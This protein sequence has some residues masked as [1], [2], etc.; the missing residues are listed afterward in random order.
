MNGDKQSER[1]AGSMSKV[2]SRVEEFFEL[3]YE[4]ACTEV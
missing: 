1:A 3:R 2:P 4:E